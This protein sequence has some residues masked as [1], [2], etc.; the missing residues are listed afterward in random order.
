M[1]IR[2]KWMIVSLSFLLMFVLPSIAC[3]APIPSPRDILENQVENAVG[4]IEE[5]LDVDEM[6]DSL[7]E[8]PEF[9]E[10]LDDGFNPDE[11]FSEL[12]ELGGEFNMDELIGGFGGSEPPEDL[13]QEAL[14]EDLPLC[15][16][17]DRECRLVELKPSTELLIPSDEDYEGRW[18]LHVQYE[19]QPAGSGNWESLEYLG[20]AWRYPGLDWELSLNFFNVTDAP[21][22]CFEVLTKEMMP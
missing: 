16:G 17:P 6:L 22:N 3:N 4:A 2:K 8:N 9:Q 15:F 12:E 5:Q 20:E 19:S 21:Q 13:M 7:S 18:C 14:A 10:L 1:Q 11:V